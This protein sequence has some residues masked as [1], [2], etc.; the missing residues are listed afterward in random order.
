MKRS[1]VEIESNDYWFKIVGMLQRNWALIDTQEGGGVVV[2]FIDDASGVFDRM[3]F[4]SMAFARD[5]L[6]ENGFEPFSENREAKKFISP[7]PAQ[8]HEANH[9]NGPIYSSGEYWR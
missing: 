6:A 2:Y 9:P 5:G 1:V 3:N 8:F 4:Q 7:P